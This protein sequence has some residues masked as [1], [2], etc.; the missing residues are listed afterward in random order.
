VDDPFHG[1]VI[2]SI[3]L[4]LPGF[5]D[6]PSPPTAWGSDDYARALLPILEDLPNP[7]VLLGHSFGGRVSLH[8]AA[9]APERVRGLVLTGVPLGTRSPQSRPKANP[10]YRVI[11]RLAALGL[12]P[13]PWLE[14]ARQ[15]YGSRDYREASGVMR[16]VS[17]RNGSR[18]LRGALPANCDAG[19][20]CLGRARHR[21]AHVRRGS[22][23][24]GF[25]RRAI[26]DRRGRRPPLAH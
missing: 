19:G 2:A 4:D 5:G 14:R 23:G 10:R 7:V 9:M 25:S 24:R 18:E 11:R 6:S 20:A 8:L 1:E 3:S 16:Q 22:G 13:D 15:R 17:R 12:I 21:G 26:D